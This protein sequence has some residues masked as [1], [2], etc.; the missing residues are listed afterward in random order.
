MKL[1][2][3]KFIGKLVSRPAPLIGVVIVVAFYGWAAVEGLFQLAGMV[4]HAPS[5]G[6]VLMPYNP[7]PNPPPL[8]SSLLPPSFTHLMGTD[9]LGRD[10]WSR[11]LYAAPIDALV[12]TVVVGGGVLVGS[13]IGVP[14]G[15]FGKTVEEVNMRF[16]DLFLAFPALILAVAIESTL[17]RALIYA[18][19]ALVIIWW[20]AYARVFR[21]E[22]LTIKNRRFIDA[23]LLSGL[24]DKRIMTKHIIPSSLNTILSYATIDLGNAILVYSILSFL[25]FGI[26]AP[27]PE[28][29]AMTAA[30]LSYFPR[31]WW[32][33]VLPG[34]V[35][36]VI[37]SGTALLGDGLRDT[38]AGGN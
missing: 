30:G 12:S 37:V 15:Y 24:S 3:P 34:I 35:I 1:R 20:P 28:W 31:W 27:A 23:A 16:T 5:L 14:A 11:I 21:A 10:I 25:G 19:V 4:L 9:E 33:A 38:F 22:A 26:P 13:L 18:I 7:N 29:G 8:A 17:G 2:I 32:Y 6:W 36:T